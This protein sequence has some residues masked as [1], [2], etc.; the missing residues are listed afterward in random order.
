M[1][2]FPNKLRGEIY[3]QPSKS[4]LHRMMIMAALSRQPV[5]ISNVNYSEDIKATLSALEAIGL[6]NYECREDRVKISPGRGNVEAVADCGESGSTLRFLIG[7]CLTLGKEVVFTGHGRLMERPQNVYAQLCEEHGFSFKRQEDRLSLCGKLSSGSYSMAGNVS[8]QFISGLI[9]ALSAVE[10][11]SRVDIT[12]EIESAGYLDIT[13][14][15]MQQFGVDVSMEGKR[16]YVRGGIN[17]P[18]TVEAPGDWSHGANFACMGAKSGGVTITGLNALSNQ[19]DRYVID[20]LRSMGA[21]VKEDGGKISFE[22]ADLKGMDIDGRDIP[23]IIPDL[24]VLLGICPGTHKIT[25]IGRLRIKES[26]RVASTCQLI[27]NIGGKAYAN[28]E[29]ITIEGVKSYKGGRVSAYNDHRIAMAAA[30]ASCYCLDIIELDDGKCVSKSAPAFWKEFT[31][32]GGVV[33]EDNV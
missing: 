13:L 32:L 14:E 7:V 3:I 24:S 21:R 9:M 27:N 29:S 11:S 16:I 1:K 8:S 30:V 33:E 15:V 4:Y 26:D 22:P 20:I 17:A 23:D 18:R 31:A 10:G 25:G 19:R 6:A 2:I 28:G 12:G 5:E